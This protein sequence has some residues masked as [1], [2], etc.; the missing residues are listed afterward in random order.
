MIRN[1]Y[2]VPGRYILAC[3]LVLFCARCSENTSSST[4]DGAGP[5]DLGSADTAGDAPQRDS[6]EMDPCLTTVQPAPGTVVTDRGAVVGASAGQTWSFKGIPYAAPPVG[7]HRWQPPQPVACW[8]DARE[9][10]SFGPAC[11]QLSLVGAYFGEEDCLTLNIWTPQEPPDG[12]GRPVMFFIHGGGNIQGGSSALNTDGSLFYDGQLLAEKTGAVVVTINYRLGA[13]G[14]LTHPELSKE[15]AH[16]TSGNYGLL[17]QIAA[18]QW[19][20]RNI[21]PFGGDPARVLLF[22]E[23][24]GAVNTCLLLA[25]PLAAGLFT[26]AIMES[27]GCWTKTEADSEAFGIQYA[28]AAGCSGA[29]SLECLRARSAEELVQTLPGKVDLIGSPLEYQPNVDGW[30]IPV[31]PLEQISAGKHNKVPLIVGS[32]AHETSIF[33]PLIMTGASYAAAVYDL[34]GAV[35]VGNAILAE[36]PVSEYGSPR[37]A[38]IALTSD[39]VFTCAARRV[40]RAAAA[41]QS[42]PVYRYSFTRGLDNGGLYLKGLGAFH[43]LELA[44]IFSFL[45][46]NGYVPLPIEIALS[47]SMIKYWGAFATSG[48]PDAAGEPAWPRYDLVTESY[49]ELADPIT[50]GAG[51]RDPQCDFWDSWLQ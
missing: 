3:C 13:L 15:G 18:L 6:L 23:S 43:G 28:E 29:D 33:V 22:G 26:A 49:L 39:L 46:A 16:Q 20:Q 5:P 42:E 30:V 36:Y 24:S 45:G 44:F 17:D 21:G 38:F 35:S 47:E 10:T 31:D 19:V 41:G 4:A 32:N 40:V 2:S 7:D 37:Q 9:A 27:G 34:A 25:S 1:L 51:L 50:A 14:L 11:P 12:E 8:S 48:V